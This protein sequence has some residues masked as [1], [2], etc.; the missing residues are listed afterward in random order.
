[1]NISEKHLR[2]M[3]PDLMQKTITNEIYK[4]PPLKRSFFSKMMNLV[5]I[6]VRHEARRKFDQKKPNVRTR[7]VI[8]CPFD[9]WPQPHG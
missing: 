4:D 8:C 1:M 5:G 3:Y 7:L 9:D 2:D 6:Q